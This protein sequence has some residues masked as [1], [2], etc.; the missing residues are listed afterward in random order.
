MQEVRL[1]LPPSLF[2]TK[3]PGPQRTTPDSEAAGDGLRDP[4][5]G[6]SLHRARADGDGVSN[7]F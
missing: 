1:R 6:L 5:G 4:R 3:G 2:P 7:P